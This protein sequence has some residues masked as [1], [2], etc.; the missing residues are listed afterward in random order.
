[1]HKIHNPKSQIALRLSTMPHYSTLPS[2]HHSFPLSWLLT[3]VSWPL[4]PQSAIP[5]PQSKIRN[6]LHSTSNSMLSL[7]LCPTTYAL[8]LNLYILLYFSAEIPPKT[9]PNRR[10]RSYPKSLYLFEIISIFYFC[11]MPYALCPM[12]L[13]TPLALI[14]S[15]KILRFRK[16]KILR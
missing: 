1:M 10:N 11:S 16:N 4:N 3:T 7:A 15:G 13:G 6:C 8:S 9:T 5:N 12:P 14:E 2:F